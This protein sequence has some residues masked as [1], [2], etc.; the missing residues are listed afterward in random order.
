MNAPAEV[1]Y[2]QVNELK[3]WPTWMPWVERDPN[4]QFS[5][6]EISSGEGAHYA[7]TSEADDVGNGA[8]TIVE[9]N[10]PS[11]IKTKIEFDGQSPAY[12]FWN[13]EAGEDGTKVTWG[14]EGDMGWT[15]IGKIFGLMIDGMVGPDFEKGLNNLKNISEEIAAKEAN[16]GEELAADQSLE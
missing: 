14:M 9:S 2:Q 12:G 8:L 16:S 6:T 11:S 15:P 10:A 7:W 1:V 3:N 4:M 13:F 5:Y